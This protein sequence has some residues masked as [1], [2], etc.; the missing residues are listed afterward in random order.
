MEKPLFAGT[1]PAPKHGPQKEGFITAP[2]RTSVS[3]A[4]ARVSARL[5]GTLVG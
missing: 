2:A 5:T 1:S 3:V 4:S